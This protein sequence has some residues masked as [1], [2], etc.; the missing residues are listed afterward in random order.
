MPHEGELD[1]L[2]QALIDVHH[3]AEQMAAV[4]W[5]LENA[6]KDLEKWQKEYVAIGLQFYDKCRRLAELRN[7]R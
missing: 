2:T 5:E 4:Q 1:K 6:R 3:S 7:G